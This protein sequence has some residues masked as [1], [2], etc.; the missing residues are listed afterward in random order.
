MWLPLDRGLVEPVLEPDRAELRP[1]KRD[2][3]LLARHR[4]E[5]RRPRIGDHLTRIASRLQAT[6]DDLVEPEAI[7]TGDFDATVAWGVDGNPGDRPR[8]VICRHRLERHGRDVHAVI[9]GRGVRDAID[10]FVGEA[11]IQAAG[12][13][14]VE[15]Q[16]LFADEPFV[17]S[18]NGEEV[19]GFRGSFRFGGHGRTL[20]IE[21]ATS[22]PERRSAENFPLKR[23]VGWSVFGHA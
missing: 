20:N 12:Q 2:E 8:D 13:L 3:R 15:V 23:R 4:A 6:P 5:V 17:A 1:A 16:R 11:V 7:G 14:I 9:H 21:P 10:G 22:N 19:A 18:Y